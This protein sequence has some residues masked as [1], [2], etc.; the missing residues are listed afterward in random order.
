MIGDFVRRL[1]VETP[2]GELRQF[3]APQAWTGTLL[4]MVND[5]WRWEGF[6]FPG[7]LTVLFDVAPRVG[8]VVE[9][10]YNST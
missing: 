8:D 1:A 10:L 9:F 7:G 6:S 5:T 4:V 3:T 2:D